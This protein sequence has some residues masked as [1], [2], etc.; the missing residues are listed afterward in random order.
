MDPG[1]ALDI[2]FHT[3]NGAAVV[4]PVGV[5][6]A[7]TCDRLRDV[8]LK[9]A[10][11]GPSAVIVD[12]SGLEV[13]SG[14][15][16]S[17]FSSVWMRVAEWP[18]LPIMLLIPDPGRYAELQQSPVVHYVPMYRDL[19][20]AVGA[21]GAAPDRRQDRLTLPGVASSSW[22]A[23]AF[24]RATCR[25]WGVEPVMGAAAAVAAEFVENVARHTG[26]DARLRLD[27][28]GALLNVAVSD[29]DPTPVGLLEP[30]RP[31]ARAGT[32]LAIV[33]DLAR[34][35]GSVP[36]LDGKVVWAVLHVS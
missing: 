28:R 3:H 16:L 13:L 35:W 33:A 27:L 31:G 20:S 19:D 8:L 36:T 15:S 4:Q 2:R 32:G 5:L 30:G 7:Y 18:G 17:V 6:D 9:V 25:R 12:L 14:A 21:V 24:V 26:S 22:A 10:T 23:R 1:L 11:D 34:A 29:S